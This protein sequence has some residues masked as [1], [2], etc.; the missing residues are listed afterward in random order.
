MTF[1]LPKEGVEIAAEIPPD[2]LQK[3][4]GSYRSEQL[5]ITVEVL[6]QIW[7]ISGLLHRN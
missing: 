3:Y 6:V 7:Y 1:D 4:L 5:G 2:E